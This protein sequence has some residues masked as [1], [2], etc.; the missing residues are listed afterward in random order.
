MQTDQGP[1]T[2]TATDEHPFWVDDL[3]A[4]ATA[5]Q[6]RPGAWL[7]TGAGARVQVGAVRAWTAS[8]QRVR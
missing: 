6:L 2:V 7:R 3:G 4:W 1:A 8:H 5:D